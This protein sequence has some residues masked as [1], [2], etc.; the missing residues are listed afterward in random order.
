MPITTS[1]WVESREL[2]INLRNDV[3]M[4]HGEGKFIEL[5]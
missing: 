1:Q 4:L 5:W 3:K 2:L